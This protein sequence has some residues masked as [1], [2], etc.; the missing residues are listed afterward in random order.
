MTLRVREVKVP[1]I[2]DLISVRESGFE[3]R[4]SVF[5][6]CALQLSVSKI[7]YIHQDGKS[8]WYD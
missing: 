8:G 3:P 5:R 6:G 7:A 1:K 4:T 2:Y